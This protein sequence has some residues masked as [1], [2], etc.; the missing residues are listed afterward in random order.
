MKLL[1]EEMSRL[2]TIKDSEYKADRVFTDTLER[3]ESNPTVQCKLE[4]ENRFNAL[5]MGEQ[6]QAWSGEVSMEPAQK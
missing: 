2:H 4:L 3:L 1:Q 6:E 5:E